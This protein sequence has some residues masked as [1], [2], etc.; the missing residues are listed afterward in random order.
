MPCWIP[1]CK[2][3]INPGIQDQSWYC[4]TAFLRSGPKLFIPIKVN[5]LALLILL[6]SCNC[7]CYRRFI[8]FGVCPGICSLLCPLTR[9][10]PPCAL[11]QK[12]LT[13]SVITGYYRE[14]LRRLKLE[15]FTWSHT[16]ER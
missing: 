9:E 1:N 12:R 3:A 14:P 16:M 4:G 10:A 13:Q 7:E 15:S 8:F 2:G 6:F 5:S 11:Q